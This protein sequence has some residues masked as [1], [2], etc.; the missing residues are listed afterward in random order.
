[1]M[2]KIYDRTA[3]RFQPSKTVMNRT[4]TTEQGRPKESHDRTTIT[5]KLQQAMS[6]F[7]ISEIEVLIFLVSFR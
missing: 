1:M 2:T 4:A 3:L 5:V 6:N 7:D